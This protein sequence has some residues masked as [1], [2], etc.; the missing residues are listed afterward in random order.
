MV[1][2]FVK[3]IRRDRFLYLLLIPFLLWYAVFMFKPMYGLQIAFRDYSIFKGISD[4]PYVGFHHFE[5]FLQSDYFLRVLKNT[6][7]I[8]LY[9]LIFA[10]PVP[11]I[12]A[13]LLNEVKNATFRKTVQTFTYLPHFISVVVV[14]GIVTNFLSPSSGLLNAVLDKLGLEKI[15]FLAVPEYFRTIFISMNIWQEAGFGA[16]IYIAALAGIN[17]EQY[18]AA[19]IDG[20]S[21][22]KRVLHVT[23][24]GILPTIMVMLILK[25][26]SLLEVG[27]EAIILLYQPATYNTADVISTYVYREGIMNGRYDMATAVGLFNAVIGFV[28]IIIANFLSKR[29]TG[30][31]LW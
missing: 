24:P 3:K 21:K 10:F 16:I 9:S 14:C 1:A 27:Y 17:P 4:S 19:V 30:N 13:L 25:I 2:T 26:G 28:L 29:I 5:V 22:W 6:L 31:G 8:S 11:I 18:E 7:M 20:A 12:L 23:L 15:Y